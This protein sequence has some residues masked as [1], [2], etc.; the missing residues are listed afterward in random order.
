[1]R[2]RS[3]SLHVAL[4]PRERELLRAAAKADRRSVAS[5]VRQLIAERTTSLETAVSALRDDR[6]ATDVIGTGASMALR[7]NVTE[8][9]Y[10]IIATEAHRQGRSV[11]GLV[12]SVM[13][14]R[15]VDDAARPT[16]PKP[17]ALNR[18]S[19]PIEGNH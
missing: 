17:A 16:V 6:T 3:C 8:D 10:S 15:L 12:R 9:E 1:M 5:Y 11:S 18:V 7:S 2:N 13:L 14:A 4:A 19:K